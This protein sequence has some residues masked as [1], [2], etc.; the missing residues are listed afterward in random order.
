MTASA[1]LYG[2]FTKTAAAA[3][4]DTGSNFSLSTADEESAAMI[5]NVSPLFI[6]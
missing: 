2:E 4:I 5:F 1:S 3:T 6:N